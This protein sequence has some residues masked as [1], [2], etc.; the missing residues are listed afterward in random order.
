MAPM[1]LVSSEGS[2]GMPWSAFPGLPKSGEPSAGQ[3]SEP[4][5]RTGQQAVVK[6][7]RTGSGPGILSPSGWQVDKNSAGHCTHRPVHPTL[8]VA[9][10]RIGR[11][12]S[13]ILVWVASG[14]TRCG[15]RVV[16]GRLAQSPLS[17]MAARGF[18]LSSNHRTR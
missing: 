4:R 3:L 7:L 11:W 2:I 10:S 15:G 14:R 13:V 6:G 5:C 18:R 17:C 12:S 1:L 9:G 16:A 8:V